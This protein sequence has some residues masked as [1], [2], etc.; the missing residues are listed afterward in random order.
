MGYQALM[1]GR[2]HG[3]EGISEPIVS[4]GKQDFV[5]SRRP[6]ESSHIAQPI[7][8]KNFFVALLIHR[9]NVASARRRSQRDVNEGDQIA[10]G[11]YARAT[12]GA[13]SLVNDVAYRTLKLLKSPLGA[14]HYQTGSV[15]CPVC[16]RDV[17]AH[18]SRR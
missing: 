1:P 8:R 12:N 18:L 15:G 9:G 10:F 4:G 7:I 3:I 11:G 5:A 17:P 16:R 13:S 2:I 6:R 14:H